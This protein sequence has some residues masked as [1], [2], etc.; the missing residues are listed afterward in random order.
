MEIQ[1]NKKLFFEY[2]LFEISAEVNAKNSI[3]TMKIIFKNTKRQFYSYKCI[4]HRKN[5]V[6]K[7]CLI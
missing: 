5:Q 2:I 1:K 3:S 4:I 6:F 7:T